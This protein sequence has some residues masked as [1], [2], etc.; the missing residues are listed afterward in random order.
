MIAQPAGDHRQWQA[1]RQT[2]N[3]RVPRE[4][5]VFVEPR[6]Q[7]VASGVEPEQEHS[8]DAGKNIRSSRRTFRDREDDVAAPR[9]CR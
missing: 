7:V 9:I 2:G 4:A 6:E 1:D 5:A 8:D 3:E